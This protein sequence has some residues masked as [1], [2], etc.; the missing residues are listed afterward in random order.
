MRQGLPSRHRNL[1]NHGRHS[2]EDSLQNCRL[3]R[4]QLPLSVQC[5]YRTTDSQPTS[6]RDLHIPPSPQIP[7]RTW[8][9]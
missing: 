6:S 8:N 3:P 2:P 7:H 9:R 1:A 4:H 5:N